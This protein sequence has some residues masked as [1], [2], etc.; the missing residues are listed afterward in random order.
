MGGKTSYAKG[1]YPDSVFED[2]LPVSSRPGPRPEKGD[3]ALIL[4]MGRSQSMDEWMGLGRQDTKFS[5]AKEA[6]RL[7]IDSLRKDDTVGVL[8][9]DTDWLV[10]SHDGI[11]YG[12]FVFELVCKRRAMT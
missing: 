6:A 3:T 11:R 10:T 4:I 12:T 5:M 9:F 1:G 2:V 8:T 7:A